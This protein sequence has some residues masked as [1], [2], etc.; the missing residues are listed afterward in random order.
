MKKSDDH[1]QV[2]GKGW[3]WLAGFDIFEDDFSGSRRPLTRQCLDW[4][5][6]RPHLAGQLGAMLLNKMHEKKW[7]KKV[8][9]SRELIVT[10]KGQQEIFALLGITL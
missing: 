1:Y 2:T 6:R 3:K 10:S 9:F 7:F 4:S 8:Q 5:E